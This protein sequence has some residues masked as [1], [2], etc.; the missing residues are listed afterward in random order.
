MRLVGEHPVA[1]APA[2]LAFLPPDLLDPRA[3]LHKESFL[4]DFNFVQQKTPSQETIQPLLT[5][6]LAFDLKPGW[7]MKEHDARGCLVDVLAAMTSG[8]NEGLF[9]IRIPDPE[10]GHALRKLSFL[11]LADRGGI[12][13]QGRLTAA[14]WDAN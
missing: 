10:A 6:R 2:A 11:V 5:S 9:D 4:P 13:F 3:F 1:S 7:T 14:N 12:H 8:T